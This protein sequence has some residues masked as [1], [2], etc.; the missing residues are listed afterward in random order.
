MLEQVAV[1]DPLPVTGAQ[2]NSGLFQGQLVQAQGTV[3]SVEVVNAFG[4]HEVMIQ[5]SE[6]DTFMA[7]VDNRTG[8]AD[9]DWTV[10]GT[11]TVIGILG[12]FDGND[13]GAQL[14]V[15]RSDDVTFDL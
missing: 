10:G 9:T 5:D 15:I 14:E 11:A 7:R 1:P 12:F 2:I 13:P 8:L 6:G 4:T 3:V